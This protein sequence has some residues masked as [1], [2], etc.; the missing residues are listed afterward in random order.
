[1]YNI[2]HMHSDTK[3]KLKCLNFIFKNEREEEIKKSCSFGYLSKP[4]LRLMNCG[5]AYGGI[6]CNEIK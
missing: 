2:V 1:M 5:I 4:E 6:N 3:L